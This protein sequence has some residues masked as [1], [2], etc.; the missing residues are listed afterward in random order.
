M[1]AEETP[2]TATQLLMDCMEDF[3]NSEATVALIIYRQE[4]GDL[5]WRTTGNMASSEVVGMLE[6]IKTAQL[7]KWMRDVDGLKD[8]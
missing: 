5:N 4:N 2:R 3:S 6:C 7:A 8:S 1:N